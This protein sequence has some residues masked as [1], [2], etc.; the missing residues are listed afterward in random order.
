MIFRKFTHQSAKKTHLH[1]FSLHH[2]WRPWTTA[3]I[4]HGTLCCTFSFVTKGDEYGFYNNTG[5]NLE[6]WLRL[7][8]KGN[9]S[10][11][12][13]L[14]GL[15]GPFKKHHGCTIYVRFSDPKSALMFKLHMG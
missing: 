10:L 4:R 5:E 8:A 6:T 1:L 14:T 9:Y 13:K 7:N 15:Q 2:L 11:E 3:V 12:S